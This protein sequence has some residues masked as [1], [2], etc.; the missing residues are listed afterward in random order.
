MAH[1]RQYEKKLQEEKAVEAQLIRASDKKAWT[2]KLTAKQPLTMDEA[3]EGIID[4]CIQLQG[5]NKQTSD[6]MN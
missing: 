1:S 3:L 4:A 2:M 6:E 5:E